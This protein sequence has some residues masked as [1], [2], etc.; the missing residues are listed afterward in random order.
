LKKLLLFFL[1]PVLVTAQDFT[2][3]S[4]AVTLD[5]VQQ[6]VSGTVEHRILGLQAEDTLYLNALKM[7]FEKV[8]LNAKPVR[9]FKNDTALFVIPARDNLH[10]NQADTLRIT[11][12]CQPKKG[13]YFIG[14]EDSSRTAPRQIW[15]QGQ[16]IDHRHWIPHRDKQTDKVVVEVQATFNV[17][18]SVVSNGQLQ[19]VSRQ[20]DQKTWRYRMQKPMSS[21]LIALMIARYDSVQTS[22]K[23]GVPLTQYFYPQRAADY[24]WY[25]RHNTEIFNF[26]QAEVGVPYPWQNYKQAP[27]QDFR[28]GAMENTTATLFGD[29]FL[30]DSIAFNDRNYTYVNAHELAHQWFGNWVTAT[31]SKHHWLHE[32]FATYYQWLSEENLYGTPFMDWE[33]HKAQEQINQASQANTLPLAHP[34]AGSARFYQKGAWVLHMLKQKLGATT[35]K[36]GMQVYLQR[37]K[38]GL[39][40]TDSLQLTLE[41]VCDCSL[42]QFFKQWVYTP[43]EPAVSLQERSS[44]NALQVAVNYTPGF[45]LPLHFT[46]HYQ[47]GLTDT[48]RFK[49]AAADSS[50]LFTLAQ[51][52]DAVST[53]ALA[54]GDDLLASLNIFKPQERWLKQ[55]ALVP[56]LLNQHR[57]LSQMPALPA[58]AYQ[59]FMRRVLG[60]E[61]AHFAL[62]TQAL[63][64]LLAL[65]DAEEQQALW[66]QALRSPNVQLQK[67]AVLRVEKPN[68]LVHN[69]LVYLRKQGQSYALRKEAIVRTVNFQ[70]QQANRWL[71]DSLWIKEPGIPGHE[72]HLTVLLYQILIFQDRA[73]FEQISL[74]SSNRYDFL[75]RIKAIEMIGALRIA[76]EATVAHLFNAFFN[77]NW[78]LRKA[79]R[80]ALQT[81]NESPNAPLIEKYRQLHQEFWTPQQQKMVLRSLGAK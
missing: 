69:R 65:A 23:N 30:V 81:L 64:N 52:K 26:L 59:Q 42:S 2:H 8:S 76:D 32:G 39:V 62:R 12:R 29:F 14:F 5:T 28:H 18:Y 24:P 66:L 50:A 33:R 80:A 11:Y 71:Y 56:G 68:P 53:W 70:N 41:E 79:A 73:A 40:T 21:Y 60:Q 35:F 13:L 58:L 49:T 38:L 54:N 47:N 15:T 10:P 67:E 43:F 22:S 74:Y 36:R 44:K 20:G 3:L 4:L 46:V 25:Y 57:V 61:Q 16:G 6:R 78:K 37:H 45:V 9:Y 63:D 1:F 72:V 51:N 55:Y 17:R 7:E 27:V 77:S 19:G 75:T 34:Q 31:G 48:L